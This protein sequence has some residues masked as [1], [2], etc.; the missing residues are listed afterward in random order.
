MIDLFFTVKIVVYL[1]S[2]QRYGGLLVHN[3]LQK[4]NL[5]GIEKAMSG[6]GVGTARTIPPMVL[7]VPTPDILVGLIKLYTIFINR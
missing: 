4:R 7:A 2:Q 1:F 5:Y 6:G 3:L